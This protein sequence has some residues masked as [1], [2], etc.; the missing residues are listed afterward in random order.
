MKTS[1]RLSAARAWPRADEI[2]L[3]I[4]KR[5]EEELA[6]TLESPTGF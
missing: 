4:G 6:A 1:N 5:E 2:R 3:G